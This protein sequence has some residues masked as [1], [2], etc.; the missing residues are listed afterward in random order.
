MF[1][2]VSAVAELVKGARLR[3]NLCIA[4]WCKSGRHRSVAVAT[5][6]QYHLQH[7]FLFRCDLVH[8]CK[9]EWPK[10]C[11]ECRGTCSLEGWCHTQRIAL[12]ETKWN[13]VLKRVSTTFALGAKA[14]EA[15]PNNRKRA[16]SISSHSS[17]GYRVDSDS[18]GGAAD[19]AG[20]RQKAAEAA[21]YEKRFG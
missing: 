12:W 13:A 6:L 20:D 11:Q 21:L 14:D 10:T 4:I 15:D 2:I 8:L 9:P 7:H 17:F 16:Y 3:D 5:W 1:H 18:D 19:A